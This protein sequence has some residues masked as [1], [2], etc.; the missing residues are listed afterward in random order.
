M[1]RFRIELFMTF[2]FYV[3]FKEHSNSITRSWDG[4]MDAFD[5]I[6]NLE[7]NGKLT[8]SFQKTWKSFF[9][10]YVRTWD[11]EA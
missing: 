2:P 10:V 11:K 1:P 6:F 4:P 8:K 3:I 5:K 9:E 7:Y